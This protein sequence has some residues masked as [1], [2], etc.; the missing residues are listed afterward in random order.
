[1]PAKIQRHCF[2]WSLSQGGLENYDLC[3]FKVIFLQ[4][5][6]SLDL[7][8]HLVFLRLCND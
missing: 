5:I 1:M 4:Q 6:I 8:G 3:N 7:E 2:V